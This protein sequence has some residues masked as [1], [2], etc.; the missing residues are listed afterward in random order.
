MTALSLTVCKWESATD[1][2]M[3][4][5]SFLGPLQDDSIL[6]FLISIYTSIVTPQGCLVIAAMELLLPLSQ[7]DPIGSALVSW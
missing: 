2:I 5:T 7:T 4:S 6:Y 3:S 1:Q